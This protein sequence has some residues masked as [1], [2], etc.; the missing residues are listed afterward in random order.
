MSAAVFM[1]SLLGCGGQIIPPEGYLAGLF[2]LAR[3]HGAVAI[4]DE[5]QVGFGRVGTHFWAF[6]AQGTS[7]YRNDG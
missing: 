1:E 4:A 5:V 7:R 6:D 2:D 3:A